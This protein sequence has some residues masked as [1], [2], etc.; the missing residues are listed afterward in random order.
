ME[1]GAIAL[2]ELYG[3]TTPA[4]VAEL[5]PDWGAHGRSGFLTGKPHTGQGR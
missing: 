1:C 2:G 3:N 5:T 4:V